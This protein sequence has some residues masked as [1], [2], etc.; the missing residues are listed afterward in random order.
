[1]K[2][3]C[4]YG[5]YDSAKREV[6][7]KS[8]KYLALFQRNM[9]FKF[10][11]Q[12]DGKMLNIQA[13]G[14]AAI[15]H[16][17]NDNW[18]G[19]QK[20]HIEEALQT[21]IGK[22]RFT[23]FTEG[24][25]KGW[26][27]S[28]QGKGQVGYIEEPAKKNTKTTYSPYKVYRTKDATSPWELKMSAL[29]GTET[30]IIS[31]KEIRFAPRQLLKAIAMWMD[32]HGSVMTEEAQMYSHAETVSEAVDVNLD[33]YWTDIDK[34]AENIRKGSMIVKT[35]KDAQSFLLQI[36]GSLKI[37]HGQTR[38]FLDGLLFHLESIHRKS[39]SPSKHGNMEIMN[40][41]SMVIRELKKYKK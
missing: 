1:V 17:F 35:M 21:T 14:G 5:A 12:G 15:M 10:G 26:T 31:N 4:A 27:I 25:I 34:M 9:K 36:A 2:I 41:L 33:G 39:M 11:E 7:E 37:K 20:I 40:D 6:R 8:R 19:I 24:S 3:P 28:I 16:K 18:D 13:F 32:K 30:R 38:D 22:Y 29:P 23:P